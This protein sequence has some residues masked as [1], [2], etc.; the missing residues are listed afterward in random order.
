MPRPE[1]V[2]IP[3][4]CL[5]LL[6]FLAAPLAAAGDDD[7]PRTASGRP[8][9]SGNYDVANLTPFERDPRLGDKQFMTADEAERIAAGMAAASAGANAVSD[10]DREA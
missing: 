7:I 1:K 8:D 9:L 5:T 10:P 2:L 6:A 4:A 3:L